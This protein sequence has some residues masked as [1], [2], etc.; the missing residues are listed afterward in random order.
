MSVFTRVRRRNVFIGVGVIALALGPAG[1]SSAQFTQSTEEISGTLQI[2]VS[3]GAGSDRAFEAVNEAFE[4]RYPDVDIEFSSVPNESFASSRS[5]RLTAGNLDITLAQPVELPSYVSGASATDDALA[6][7]AGLFLD[8]TDEPFMSNFTPSVIESLRY[9]ERSYTV[10]TGLSY[11]TGVFYNKAIFDELG[12]DVPTTWEEFEAVVAA[13]QEAGITP[14][15]I[16][17]KDSWPAGLTML[18]A[19]QS[20]YPAADDKRDLAEGLW[21]G[22][23]SLTGEREVEVLERVK[24]MYDAAQ[25]NF[26]GIAYA[27]IPGSFATGDVAMTVDGTWNQTTIDTAVDGAFDYGY[28]PLPAS[29]DAADNAVL[30]GKVELRMVVASNAPNTAAALAYLAFFAEPEN[31][32]TFVEISG[33]ASAQP[34]IPAS[35]FLES[36]ASYTET[37]SPAWDTIWVP[38]VDAGPAALFPFNYTAISP[39]GTMSVEDAAAAAQ[40]DWDAGI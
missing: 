32:A 1:A 6:A 2:L 16:G 20:L 28:F 31:Y 27:A 34:D 9:H 18:A 22:S 25:T 26:S 37:F 10:P 5:S 14:L 17:G 38:N 21:S 4:T 19:V 29:D 40:D 15:G 13:L 8:L 23:E 36:I 24:A 33:F 35:P 11:Y 12:L 39:L 3:S 7:D 30:G